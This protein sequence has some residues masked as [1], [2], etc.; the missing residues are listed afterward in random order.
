M[1]PSWAAGR[2]CCAES[3]RCSSTGPRCRR[4]P[5]R[6]ER[7]VSDR[8]LRGGS[9]FP[10]RS[11]RAGSC[12]PRVSE[13]RYPPTSWVWFYRCVAPP[14]RWSGATT[15]PRGSHPTRRSSTPPR[16]RRTTGATSSSPGGAAAATV[17]RFTAGTAPS[18]RSRLRKRGTPRDGPTHGSPSASTPSPRCS[19]AR[20]ETRWRAR[21][22][23]RRFWRRPSPSSPREWPRLRSCCPAPTPRSCSGRSQGFC[24]PGTGISSWVTCVDPSR[25]SSGT[26]RASTPTSSWSWSPG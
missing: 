25:P 6:L 10:T 19:C 24:S 15:P 12:S 14:P 13:G 18:R 4:R 7:R 21:T 2:E 20:R 11:A 1:A 16:T 23:S 9:V 17:S 26:C 8:R 22:G 5:R 3:E